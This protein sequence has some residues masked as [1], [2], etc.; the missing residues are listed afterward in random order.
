MQK[1]QLPYMR[2]SYNIDNTKYEL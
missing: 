1:D 2:R